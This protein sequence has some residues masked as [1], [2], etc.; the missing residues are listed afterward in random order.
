MK[1]EWIVSFVLCIIFF[2]VKVS[3]KNID[4]VMVLFVN[5]G[6]GVTSSKL[7]TSE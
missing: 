6:L 4:Q 2:L 3:R 7:Y 5:L 1:I